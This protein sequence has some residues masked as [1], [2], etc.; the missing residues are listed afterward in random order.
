MRV[1]PK[2][3]IKAIEAVLSELFSRARVRFLGREYG[4][5]K[6]LFGYA[7]REELSLPGVLDNAAKLE[8]FNP[9][10]RLKDSLSNMVKN[11][12]ES[13]ESKAKSKVIFGI[14][15]VLNESEGKDLDFETVLGGQVAEVMTEITNDVKR[16]VDTE[17][18][19]ARNAGNLD[20]ISKISAAHKIEDPVIYF[21]PVRDNNLCKECEKLH[22][23]AGKGSKPRVWK[24]SEIGH[25]YHKKGEENPKMGGLH[26]NCRCSASILLKG[27][28][29]DDTGRLKFISLEHD[30]LKSQRD[31]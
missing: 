25:S 26:P 9:N 22:L 16:M 8:G 2:V 31:S 27:F 11:Y 14:Q 15:N 3:A 1:L 28:G 5:K 23:V 24:L 30:E 7:F 13:Y 20:V 6:I 4:P 21:A 18:T 12:F 10:K 19:R 17:T 29:F